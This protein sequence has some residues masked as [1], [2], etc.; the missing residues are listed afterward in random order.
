MF[1]IARS[2]HFADG[3]DE[4]H[5]MVLARD[6]LRPYGAAAKATTR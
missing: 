6:E 3:P 1:A 5:K 2:L 4:V